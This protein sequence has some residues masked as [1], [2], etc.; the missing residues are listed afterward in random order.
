M[1]SKNKTPT[2]GRIRLAQSFAGGL[3]LACFLAAAPSQAAREKQKSPVTQDQPSPDVGEKKPANISP[4]AQAVLDQ[5]GEAYDKLDAAE[6]KGHIQADVEM[7]GQKQKMKHEFTSAFQAPNKFRHE[8]EDG[9]LIGSTGEKTYVFQKSA[10]AFFQQKS[11][12]GKVAIAQ[13]PSP[14]PQLLQTQNPSL[15][16]AIIKDP[17]RGMIANMSEI[18]KIADVRIQDQSYPALALTPQDGQTKITLLMDAQSH[19]LKRLEIEIAPGT[20]KDGKTDSGLQSVKA[21]I[22]YTTIQPQAKFPGDHFAWSPPEGAKDLAAQKEKTSAKDL[23]GK[24]AP[25][26]TLESADGQSVS[27]SDLKGKVVVLDFWATWCPPCVKSLPH[28]DQLYQQTAGDRVRVFAVNLKED[29]QQVHSFLQ[30]KGLSLPVLM[31]REGE[32]AQKFNI[33][34]I[35]QTIVIGKDG[36]IRKVFVGAGGDTAE[37]IREEVEFASGENEARGD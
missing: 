18:T 10:N 24:P 9:L 32:V 8:L 21:Q 34:A 13:L 12:D 27:L 11:A 30:S 26:F 17:V 7:A 33:H 6:F 29:D 25:D 19:L 35:P 22:E 5:L 4:E 36:S 14:I 28:L 31:D 2:Q 16:F 3:I 37:Q 1:K 15:L 23:I 20:L